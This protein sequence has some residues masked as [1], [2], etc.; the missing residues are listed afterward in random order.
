M[1]LGMISKGAAAAALAAGLCSAASAAVLSIQNPGGGT[2]IGAQIRWGGSGFEA[3]IREI[4][5]PNTNAVEVGNLDP[6]GA[7]VWVLNQ[8]YA[9][10]VDYAASTGTISL[11]VDFNRDGTFGVGESISRSTF[12]A[13]GMTSY[14]GYGFRYL[15][16]FGTE[17]NSTARS[18]IKNLT[19]NG[20]SMPDFI[21]T[22]NQPSGGSSDMFYDDNSG[23]GTPW[24]ISGTLT[25]TAAPARGNE[26][27]SYVFNFRAPELIPVA[28]AV[29]E[30]GSLGLA[31]LGSI[32]ACMAGFRRRRS[33]L[34]AQAAL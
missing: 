11:S 19:I 8:G 2:E 25:F 22:T 27:P 3:A 16:I 30:P 34:K 20:M 1:K 5:A 12:E 33:N 31:A 7:P 29:P 24:T 14:A 32:L 23:D 9:F 10:V 28:Q 18:N 26:R 15:Q 4:K 13:P 21:P 6:V 17:A